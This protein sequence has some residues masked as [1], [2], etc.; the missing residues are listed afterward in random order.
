MTHPVPLAGWLDSDMTNH[1]AP[2][3]ASACP[4][5]MIKH[6][7]PGAA[8]ARPGVA[9]STSSTCFQQDRALPPRAPV[10]GTMTIS[11]PIP[12]PATAGLGLWVTEDLSL[13]LRTMP[14]LATGRGASSRQEPAFTI[15]SW[16]VHPPSAWEG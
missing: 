8:T 9:Q 1:L 3:T 11:E 6:R 2:D 4:G 13:T 12:G 15:A 5:V 16:L 10:R 7:T 14:P